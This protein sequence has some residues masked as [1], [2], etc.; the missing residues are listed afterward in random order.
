MPMLRRPRRYRIQVMSGTR[1][2]FGWLTGELKADARRLQAV[3][4]RRRFTAASD[5]DAYN[6]PWESVTFLEKDHRQDADAT[7]SARAPSKTTAGPSNEID[8]RTTGQRTADP[9]ARFG[10]GDR[11]EL[12]KS[13]A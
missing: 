1:K 2:A 12:E 13:V 10:N 8:Q 4:V 7:K 6:L 5:T 9:G 3:S 11:G